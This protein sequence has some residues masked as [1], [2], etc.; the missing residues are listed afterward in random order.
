MAI[1]NNFQYLIFINALC[2]TRQLNFYW[3]LTNPKSILTYLYFHW[4][5]LFF[6]A[7]VVLSQLIVSCVISLFCIWLIILFRTT[8][9]SDSFLALLIFLI[10]SS[11]FKN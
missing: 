10:F 9:P 2:R 5:W 8:C 4:N 6:G 11:H 1:K 7:R 3:S